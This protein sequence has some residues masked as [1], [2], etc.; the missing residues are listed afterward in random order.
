MAASRCADADDTAYFSHHSQNFTTLTEYCHRA[1][2]IDADDFRE[3]ST[4]IKPG[5]H[6]TKRF[7]FMR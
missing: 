3:M 6:N 7:I 2:L 1:I 4:L 5:A